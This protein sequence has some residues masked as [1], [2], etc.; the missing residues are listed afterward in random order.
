MS[1]E[2][3]D[4]V[5]IM[6]AGA[7][8]YEA[9]AN[10]RLANAKV[11]NEIDRAIYLGEVKDAISDE[12][13]Q[14]RV[15]DD[16]L[17]KEYER[18]LESLDAL[19]TDLE[20]LDIDWK[21]Y[22]NNVPDNPQDR[23]EDMLAIFKDEADFKYDSFKSTADITSDIEEN[24][25]QIKA[26]TD[27]NNFMLRRAGRLKEEAEKGAKE[28]EKFA[29]QAN[30][31]E[32]LNYYDYAEQIFKKPKEYLLTEDMIKSFQQAQMGMQEGD[33]GFGVFGPQTQQQWTGPTILDPG[34]DKMYGTPDDAMKGLTVQGAAFM[35][36]SPD[37]KEQIDRKNAL[38][39]LAA[40]N[41]AQ[42]A[43]TKTEKIKTHSDWW[44]TTTSDIKLHTTILGTQRTKTNKQFQGRAKW[45]LSKLKGIPAEGVNS[46]EDLNKLK[47]HA[48]DNILSSMMW[49]TGREGSYLFGID[50]QYTPASI[51]SILSADTSDEV[52]VHKLYDYLIPAD[53]SV[54]TKNGLR[55]DVAKYIDLNPGWGQGDAEQ[56]ELVETLKLWK[57]TYDRKKNY[58]DLYGTSQANQ[59]QTGQADPATATATPQTGTGTGSQASAEEL[60]RMNESLNILNQEYP[61]IYQHSSGT[62]DSLAYPQSEWGPRHQEILDSLANIQ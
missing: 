15:N 39:I 8:V 41:K 61:G 40:R 43:K 31:D 36:A 28:A 26:T 30:Y 50:L 45:D 42:S 19:E 32:V 54:S 7:N 4:L 9:T 52:K 20:T 33:P 53:E 13:Y 34:T 17:A 12:N 51:K 49:A 3:D 22:V 48:E 6:N 59:Q 24:R 18:S 46:V 55:A 38:S 11:T 16:L 47:L 58:L 25:A 23:T 21:N 27:K 14:M 1:K 60:A 35:E 62:I 10:S 37:T 44:K 5:K 57:Y 29:K 56:I 2:L